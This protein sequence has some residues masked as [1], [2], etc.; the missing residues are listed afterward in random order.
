MGGVEPL[1]TLSSFYHCPG[2]NYSLKIWFLHKARP[3]LC[4][5]A[6]TSARNSF[7]DFYKY[8]VICYTQYTIYNFSFLST[9]YDFVVF[10]YLYRSVP[11]TFQN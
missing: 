11:L 8:D 2:V 6:E 10:V 1:L 7:P 3:L 9:I 5:Q 4:S